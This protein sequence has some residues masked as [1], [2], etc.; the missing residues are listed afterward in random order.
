M[1]IFKGLK[2]P[3]RS[4]EK[5]HPTTTKPKDTTCFRPIPGFGIKIAPYKSVA[6]NRWEEKWNCLKSKLRK[7]K[8]RRAVAAAAL[9]LVCR[10]LAAAPGRCELTRP[11]LSKAVK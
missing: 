3:F 4:A 2:K 9:A 1:L 11:G 7:Q 6:R 8:I 10:E 5:S